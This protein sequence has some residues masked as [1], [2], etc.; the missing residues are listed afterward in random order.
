MELLPLR[1]HFR[2]RFLSLSPLVVVGLGQRLPPPIVMRDGFLVEVSTPRRLHL[3]YTGMFSS[4]LVFTGIYE[5]FAV[6]Q[7]R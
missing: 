5:L 2:R 4:F 1:P 7:V 3:R 6:L